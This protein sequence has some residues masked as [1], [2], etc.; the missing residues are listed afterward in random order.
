MSRKTVAGE[1]IPPQQSI[2]PAP[3]IQA[4]SLFTRALGEATVGYAPRGSVNDH[5]AMHT[6]PVF[7]ER[8]S[9][10]ARR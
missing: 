2:A 6:P 3:G 7:T 8:G 1:C 10:S 5:L 9:I 4:T